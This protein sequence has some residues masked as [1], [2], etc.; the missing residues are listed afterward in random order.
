MGAIKIDLD[1]KDIPWMAFGH[2][3]AFIER[4]LEL[5]IS[6]VQVHDTNKGYHI[7]LY[8]EKEIPDMAIVAIQAILG[9][10]WRR[11]T[12]NARRVTNGT[13]AWNVLFIKKSK[14]GKVISEEKFNQAITD[15]LL[16]EINSEMMSWEG[17]S[18]IESINAI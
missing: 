1:T 16:F 6:E 9:S 15:A 8:F 10:D 7:Y 13:P 12:Y 3:I 5:S 14:D 18:A 4:H 2:R 11:E 17:I